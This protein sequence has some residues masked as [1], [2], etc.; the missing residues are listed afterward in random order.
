V[1]LLVVTQYFWPESF[2]INEVVSSLVERGISVDVLTGKPNYPD[3]DVFPGYRANGCMTENWQGARI[4]RVPMIPRGLKSAVRLA[5]NYLSFVF[6]G[7]IAGA[8]LL[9]NTKP[10]VI[11]VYAPSPLLQALPA[12]L[13]GRIKRVPVVIY[14]Q[15]LWPESIE[16]TG[17]VRNRL[18]I[19][20]VEKVVRFIY[21]RANL[22]MV[23]SRPFE[24]AIRRFSP[25]AKIIYYPNSVDASF[26]DPSEGPRLDIPELDG[27]FSVVF[28]GNIGSAQAVEVIVEAAERLSSYADIRLVVL[29]SGSKLEWMHQQKRDR[30]LHNLHLPGRFP[31]ETMPYLLAKASALLVTLA[32]KPIFAATVPNKIQAYMAVGRPVIACMNGEGA[33]LVAEAQVGLTA[34]AED[35]DGLAKIIIELYQMSPDERNQLGANGQA[36]YR[37]HFDHEML[38]SKLIEQL[39]NVMREN[40][41]NTGSRC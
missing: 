5:L 35:A 19:R 4:F 3:G 20:M 12:I 28:A 31:V 13:I 6:A 17:Y 32:D 9:R 29:G 22:I 7:A 1:R 25:T 21:R 34:S 14:V 15:D 23:S 33:R 8:W 37:A 11:F 38:V 18:I 27:G 16:A 2:R 26:C 40:H 30:K 36:Y 24:A 10:D 41:E 39:G